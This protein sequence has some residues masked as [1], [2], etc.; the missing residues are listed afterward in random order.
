[1]NVLAVHLLVIGGTRHEAELAE[2][3]ELREEAELGAVA[4]ERVEVAKQ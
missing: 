1:V 3:G 2:A 4:V